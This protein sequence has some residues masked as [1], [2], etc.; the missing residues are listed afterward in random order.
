M[1]YTRNKNSRLIKSMFARGKEIE[2]VVKRT[3]TSELATLDNCTDEEKAQSDK[4][5]KLESNSI[6][7]V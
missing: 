5:Q 4:K 1:A 3:S 2:D 6:T 7:N